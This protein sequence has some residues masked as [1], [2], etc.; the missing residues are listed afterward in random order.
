MKDIPETDAAA[1][2]KLFDTLR[3]LVEQAQK[4]PAVGPAR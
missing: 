2:A 1:R 4:D 3:W